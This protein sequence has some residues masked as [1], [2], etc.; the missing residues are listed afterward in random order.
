MIKQTIQI[1]GGECVNNW[2]PQCTHLTVKE[3]VLTVK[4]LHALLD[5]KPIIMM[6]FWDK[7]L[8]C[9][10]KKIPPPDASEFKPPVAEKM[11]DHN[12]LCFNPERKQLFKGKVFVFPDSKIQGKMKD[13]IEKAGIIIALL[14]WFHISS[15]W[16]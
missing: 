10:K 5:D 15:I 13:I 6:K 8:E 14:K 11:I 1:L 2:S 3:V 12:A 4:V 16:G 9:V 7:F